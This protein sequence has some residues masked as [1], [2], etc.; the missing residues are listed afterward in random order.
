MPVYKHESGCWMY[1]FSRRINGQRVRKRQLL[2]QGWTR[3]QADAYERAQSAALY[4]VAS[5][6]AKPRHTIDAA[7][8]CYVKERAPELKHGANVEREL[9]G[10]RDWWTGRAIEDLPKVC[11][12][13]AEDQAGA[14]APATVKNRIAYLRA[15]CRYA[16][17]RY[18]M[19]DTDPGAKVQAPAVR[20][21]RDTVISRRDMLRLA[22]A[23][24]HKPTRALIRVL[25]YSGMRLGEA[26]AAER[27]PGAFVLADTKNG[28][29]RIVPMHPRIR[30]AA[31]IPPPERSKLYYWWYVATK[32]AGMDGVRVHD[33]R[34]SAASHMV[35]QGIDLGTVAAVLGH[36]T[37]Q[38]TKRYSHHAIERLAE[39][40]GTIGRRSKN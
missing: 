35:S 25:W 30:T 27:I 8:S 36:K 5:G 38:T 29:P 39:A 18:D 22:R 16:W 7:V 9:E 1:E 21:A 14:L 23:C 6:I 20:N 28:T 32:K 12:E 4:A 10:M 37:M 19:A 40:V 13:Y 24:P 2:P 31:K 34:H 33:L 3:A 26:E 17:K 11:R 15:A